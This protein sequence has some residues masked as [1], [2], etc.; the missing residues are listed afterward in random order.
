[1]KI[2]CL[3]L[4][5]FPFLLRA[6]PDA[7]RWEIAADGGIQTERARLTGGREHSDHIE[8]AGRAV[9]AVVKWKVTDQG[10]VELDRWVRWPMLREQKDDTHASVN[11][12]FR[13]QDDPVPVIDGRAYQ[14]APATVFRIHGMLS[15]TESSGKLAVTRTVFPSVHL[16]C[17]LERWEIRNISTM[18]VEIR[19]PATV[20]EELQPREKF[21]WSAHIMRTQWIGGGK[22]RLMPGEQLLT[23]MIFSSR[24]ENDPA[25][26]PDIPAEWSGRETFI[27]G[28]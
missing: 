21:L 2:H 11:Y 20:Q 10:V 28:L 4:S 23:G 13:S 14:A 7:G 24:Q 9:N 25:V 19:I 15:W 12:S 6:A 3:L 27:R 18:P 16:P 26:F 17:L 5:C 22:R 8:M 1:M